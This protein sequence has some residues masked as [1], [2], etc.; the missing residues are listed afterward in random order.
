LKLPINT[1]KDLLVEAQVDKEP[2][3]DQELEAEG[4]AKDEDGVIPYPQEVQS[5]DDEEEGDYDM[6]PRASTGRRKRTGEVVSIF[7]S[8]S[9]QC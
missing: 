3:V 4:Q 8:S 5:E 2:P 9:L 1:R 7:T 6:P